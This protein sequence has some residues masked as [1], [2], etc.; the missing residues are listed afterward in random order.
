MIYFNVP[1]FI[2]TEFKYMREA[3]ENHKICG[4]G[5]FT[6]KCNEWIEK[7]F[8]ARKALLTTSG[9]TALEMAAL[10]CGIKP[11]DEV[12]L[13][14]YTFSSTATAFVLAGAKLVFVDIRPDTMNIDENK[15]ESAITDRTKVICVMHY[16]GV[17]CEMDTIM[18]IAKRYDLKV[19]ED[20]AQGVMSTYKGKV[21]GTIGDFGCY[22]FHETKNYSMG[23]GGAIVINDEKYIEKAEVL[24]EKGTNR[25]QFFRGQ[26]AKYNWVDYGSSYLPS[27][28]NAAYLWAQLQTADEINQNRLDTWEQ[29]KRAFKQLAFEGKIEL[30]TIPIVCTHNAH[31]FYI[32]CQDLKTRTAYIDYMKAHDILCV[33]H[34]VPLHSAPAGIKYGRF[35][36]EDVYTT[37][38][39]DRLVRLP[40]YYA[41][42]PS[43]QQKVI[44]MTLEFFQNH[45]AA[46]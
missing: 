39:S 19:V 23:E 38:E 15:I 31:M 42:N 45:E 3:V 26:V 10:L 14:S 22:S 25:S 37:S 41:M 34:Y 9:T 24:R 28:L 5:M 29:Y 12:I 33:F 17:A 1:P 40:M 27:D 43:D 36:G 13:P 18:D 6:K 44:D 7:R 32:K 8:N 35:D 2:G 4:D 11:G 21:L 30:P 46:Y 16:A 20:A